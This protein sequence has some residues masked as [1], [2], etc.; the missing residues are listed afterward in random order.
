MKNLR[1]LLLV[2]ALALA[3]TAGTCTSDKIV[4]LV[5]GV[6]TTAEFIASGDVNTYDDTQTVDV[7]EDLDLES[8]LDDAGI[9]PAD[10]HEVQ[11]VQVFYRITQPE[12][13]RSI[14]DGAL[15]FT[16]PGAASPGPHLVISGFTADASAATDWIDVS[17]LLQPGINQINDFLAEYLAELKGTGPP[18]SNTTFEYHVSGNSIPASTPTDFRWELKLVIQVVGEREFTVPFGA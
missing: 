10:V 4:E 3:L 15:E 7:K 11:L 16:R 13:G 14:T 9:D 6:P 5:I 18:V 12:A 2:P 17:E 8:E 1:T